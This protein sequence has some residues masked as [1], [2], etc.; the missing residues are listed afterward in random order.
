ME[1]WKFPIPVKEE[2]AISMPSNALLL[3]VAE[4]CGEGQLWACV[5]P[6]SPR[7]SRRFWVRG[8]GWKIEG[9]ANYV[10]TWMTN[11]GLLVWHLFEPK[12]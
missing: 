12:N 7:V 8:T 2:I 5:D 1:V 10:G 9:G 4:Q 6:S 3:H 11:S